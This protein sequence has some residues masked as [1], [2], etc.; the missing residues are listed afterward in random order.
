MGRE[1]LVKVYVCPDEERS[2]DTIWKWSWLTR[3]LWIS[4]YWEETKRTLQ[5]VLSLLAELDVKFMLDCPCGLGFKTILFA[6]AGYEVEGADASAIAIKHA[7]ELTREHGLRIRFFRS[8]F[9]G[10]GKHCRRKY[11]CVY[12]DYFDE[13]ESKNILMA[14]ARSIHSVLR[15]GGKFIFCSPSPELTKSDLKE[16]IEREWRGR[17]WLKIDPLV[18]KGDLKLVYIEIASKTSEG[19]RENRIYLIVEKGVSRAEIASIMNPRIKWTFQDYAKVLEEVGFRRIDY[20]GK[21]E[22]EGLIVAMK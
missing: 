17:R 11:D 20:V 16:L 7:R 19:I 22:L 1:E 13:L 6:K 4:E 12:S 21:D 10:L 3:E 15:E 9:E 2:W 5:P 8:R 18:K 14:S